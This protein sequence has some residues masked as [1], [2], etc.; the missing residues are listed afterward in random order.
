MNACGLIVLFN[1][2]TSS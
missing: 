1:Y 2:D